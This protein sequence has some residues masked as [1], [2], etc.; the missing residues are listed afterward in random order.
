MPSMSRDH[1]GVTG[2]KITYDIHPDRDVYEAN[3]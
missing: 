3:D 2:A 1:T